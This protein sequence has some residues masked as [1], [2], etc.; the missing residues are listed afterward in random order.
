[1]H[2]VK[3]VK[4]QA[5]NIQFESTQDHSKWVV[6]MNNKKNKSWV[7]IGDINRAVNISTII[8][9]Y[10]FA[11]YVIHIPKKILSFLCRILSTIE[12]VVQ[13]V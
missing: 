11:G 3:S 2:N 10:I 4:L 9:K 6:T 12:A 5:A 1:M 7:C 8:Y 13:S